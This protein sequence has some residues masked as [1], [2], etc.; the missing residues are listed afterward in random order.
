MNESR[1]K[2][3]VTVVGIIA[4]FSL[5][6]FLYI[7]QPIGY[8]ISG[9]V[10]SN[11]VITTLALLF[12]PIVG[13]FVGA[14]SNLI[15]AIVNGFLR[16]SILSILLPC[17]YGFIIGKIFENKT[18]K[19]DDKNTIGG[20]GIFSLLSVGL[21][22]VT[23][24]FYNIFYLIIIGVLSRKGILY[25]VGLSEFIRLQIKSIINSLIVGVISF[26]LILFYHKILKLCIPFFPNYKYSGNKESEELS[27]KALQHML[28]KEWKEAASYYEKAAELGH[29]GAQ[30][31]LGEFYSEGKG[32]NKNGNKAVYWYKR[33]A[34]QGHSDAQY[35][36]A[37]L[38][39][40]GEII[41]CN[42]TKAKYWF[43]RAIKQRNEA[44]LNYESNLIK[45]WRSIGEVCRDPTLIVL[46]ILAGIILGGIMAYR[47]GFLGFIIGVVGGCII[48]RTMRLKL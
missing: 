9:G 42:N 38:Y 14:I 3:I 29:M 32:V 26:L 12:G 22:I 45:Q 39:Q 8:Y 44:A 25:S 20:I 19:A 46:S 17:L 2:V 41:G 13:G 43:K 47:L 4:A 23:N 1:V 35:N 34:G 16:W 36:L 24:I 10:L 28:S 30:Y 18:I 6:K 11:V 33:A 27:K 31:A 5:M 37:V 21:Y 40:R 48:V 7:Q 15:I